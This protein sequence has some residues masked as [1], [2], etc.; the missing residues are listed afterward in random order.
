LEKLSESQNVRLSPGSRFGADGFIRVPLVKP[1][2]ALKEAVKRLKAFKA[3][4]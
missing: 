4:L 3:S 1:V 2:P